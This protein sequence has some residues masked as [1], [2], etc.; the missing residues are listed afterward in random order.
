[1]TD[2]PAR[3][4]RSGLIDR[5]VTTLDS[6]VRVALVVA[7]VAFWYL[8]SIHHPPPCSFVLGMCRY[9][10]LPA[11]LRCGGG[12]P[13]PKCEL[14]KMD[15]KLLTIDLHYAKQ[16][17]RK[18]CSAAGVECL[19]TFD[20]SDIELSRVQSVLSDSSA[21][22]QSVFFQVSPLEWMTRDDTALPHFLV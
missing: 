17:T 2:R 9:G 16:G 18:L 21:P 11:E 5:L 20:Q 22:Q 15:G 10:S 14:L 7:L 12:M 1:M 8:Q 3:E 19:T 13:Q 6:L 4:P